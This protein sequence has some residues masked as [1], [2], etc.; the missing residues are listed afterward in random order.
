ML[1]DKTRAELIEKHGPIGEWTAP[2]GRTVAVRKPTS[3]DYRA[4]IA[5]V[6]NDKSN[7][8]AEIRDLVRKCVAFPDGAAADSIFDEYPAG[9][10]ELSAAIT[11]L[12]GGGEGNGARIRK[13]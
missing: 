10:L 6:A 13:N 1:D 5:K 3:S 4:F 7:K 8:E 2:D 11:E 9:P 12:A